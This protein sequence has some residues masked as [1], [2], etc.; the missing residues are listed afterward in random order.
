M[1]KARFGSYSV[2]IWYVRSRGN[3]SVHGK[4]IV[5]RPVQLLNF[6]D[7]RGEPVFGIFSNETIFDA[8]TVKGHVLLSVAKVFTEADTNLF[9]DEIDVLVVF[10]GSDAGGHAVFYLDASVYLHK[11]RCPRQE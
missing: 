11:E 10:D 1:A 9:S 4:P 5:L 2:G 3:V 6:A 8:D 7:P